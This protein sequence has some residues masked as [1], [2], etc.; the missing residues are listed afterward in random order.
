MELATNEAC[1]ALQKAADDMVHFYDVH[2][3]HAPIY[4]VG[5]RVCVMCWELNSK[6]I[7]GHQRRIGS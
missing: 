4:K 5:D 7:G 3:Q 2:H 1:S 6:G